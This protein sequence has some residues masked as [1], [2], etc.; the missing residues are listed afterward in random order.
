MTF[1]ATLCAQLA[2]WL[3]SKGWTALSDLFAKLARRSEIQ[4]EADTSVQPL[5]DAKTGDAVDKATDSTLN[6]T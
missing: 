6:G 4:K 3:L 2:E 5:K 1:L